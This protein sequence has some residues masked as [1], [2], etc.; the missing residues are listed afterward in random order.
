MRVAVLLIAALLG[1][2]CS[3]K[4]GGGERPGPITEFGMIVAKEAVEMESVQRESQVN[5][6]FHAS[7]SSGGGVAIG[8]GF[9]MSPFQSSQT[10]ENPIRYEIQ[11]Q[12]GDRVTIYHLSSMFEINDCVMITAYPDEETN[13]P[14]MVRSKDGCTQ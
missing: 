8:L 3:G 6:S 14:E 13:P 5:T 11:M 10:V 7:I 2:S 4:Q 12:D 9:L 1:S